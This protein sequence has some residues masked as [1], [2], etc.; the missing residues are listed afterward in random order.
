MITVIIPEWVLWVALIMWAIS[1]ILRVI[2]W[3]VNR[4]L[5]GVIA[6]TK[7]EAGLQ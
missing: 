7:A 3:R 4:H 1:N 2:L 5:E 6:K